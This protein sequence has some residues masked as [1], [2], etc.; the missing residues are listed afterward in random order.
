MNRNVSCTSRSGVVSKVTS[1]NI[2]VNIVSVSACFSCRAKGLCSAFEQKEKVILVPNTG[3]QVE[4]GDMVNVSVE[5]GMGIRAALL[6]W[7]L[8]AVVVAATLVLLLDA[9]IEELPAGIAALSTLA[10]YY[11][12]IYLIREKLKKQLYIYIEKQTES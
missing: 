3:Q 5:T 4:C 9:G 11:F 2:A 6:A 7:F 8:P 10:G 1:E 12:L